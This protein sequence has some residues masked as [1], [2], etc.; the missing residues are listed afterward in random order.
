MKF[1]VSPTCLSNDFAPKSPFKFGT[2]W[3]V[4]FFQP[5]FDV[6]SQWGHYG[7]L[8]LTEKPPEYQQCAE[9]KQNHNGFWLLSPHIDAHKSDWLFCPPV[10][11]L[12]GAFLILL[13][14]VT[15]F[16][17][18]AKV[19]NFLVFC[20]LQTKIFPISPPLIVLVLAWY[21][22]RSPYHDTLDPIDFYVSLIF[23]T[24]A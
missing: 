10:H 18:G 3:T 6:W 16:R 9:I 17:G 12:T 22:I 21:C 11:V 23:C 19:F 5:Q 1:R 2:I 8:F 7:T 13:C 14:V 20:W 15:L 4:V 24:R